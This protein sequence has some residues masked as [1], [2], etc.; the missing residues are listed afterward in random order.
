MVIRRPLTLTIVL[1]ALMPLL[2]E[3][4]AF[5][6]PRLGR[7]MQRDPWGY[8]DGGNLYQYVRSA[9][10][11]YV[12]RDGAA[13]QNTSGPTSGLAPNRAQKGWT[14]SLRLGP[15]WL[16]DGDPDYAIDIWHNL[17]PAQPADAKQIW[18]AL[19]CERTYMYVDD[20][21]PSKCKLKSD[22]SYIIDIVDTV[23]LNRVPDHLAL[24]LINYKMC[25]L[26]E[27]CSHKIGF[28]DGKSNYAQQTN[29]KATQALA[30]KISD[31]MRPPIGTFRRTYA[32]LRKKNCR[33][34]PQF[35]K[36]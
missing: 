17:P 12:D 2:P 7:F 32:Y 20:R 16:G 3:A 5:H 8:V 18:Q 24:E 19:T 33:C 21:D 6:H 11:N 10:V 9:P 28:D 35:Q 36:V 31:A 15:Q 29:V 1:L 34:C 4:R 25:F 27:V 30:N 23:D 22:T 26:A 13:A 14:R